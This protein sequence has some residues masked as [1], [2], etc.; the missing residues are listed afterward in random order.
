[1]I[2][3]VFKPAEAEI[4]TGILIKPDSGESEGLGI[5][6]PGHSIDG[7]T[8]GITQPQNSGD[9]IEGFTRCIIAG[10]ARISKSE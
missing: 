10:L 7:R 6:L 1:L 4:I 9:L 2:T 5:T 8:S 3:A